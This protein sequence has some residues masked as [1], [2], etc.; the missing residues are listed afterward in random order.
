[1]ANPVTGGLKRIEVAAANK[2]KKSDT[3]MSEGSSAKHKVAVK[4]VP[5]AKVKRK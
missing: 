1:M 2:G 5:K 4:K 3:R